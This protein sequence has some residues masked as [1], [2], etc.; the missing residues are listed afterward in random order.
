MFDCRLPGRTADFS[1]KSSS[2]AHA[3]K[4]HEFH[5]VK[6]PNKSLTK[7]TSDFGTTFIAPL[8]VFW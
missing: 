4:I 2:V 6:Y 5:G 1:A 8:C 7:K 3:E